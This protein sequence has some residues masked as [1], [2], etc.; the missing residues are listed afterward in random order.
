MGSELVVGELYVEYDVSL[1]TPELYGSS[2]VSGGSIISG[3]TVSAGNP[4]GNAPTADMQNFGFT[5]GTNSII[6]FQN[7]GT[8]VLTFEYAGTSITVVPASM[9]LGADV[10]QIGATQSVI[11]AGSTSAMMQ[12][13]LLVHGLL[14]ATF[15]HQLTATTVTATLLT[16]AVAPTDSVN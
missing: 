10:T 8:Y 15:D 7:V 5:V 2:E 6:Y 1:M 13:N 16:V 11:G 14:N 12:I 9:V 3:G 4:L